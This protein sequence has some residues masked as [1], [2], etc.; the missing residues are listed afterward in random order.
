M[1]H[2]G[3]GDLSVLLDDVHV[4][5]GGSS[6]GYF[7]VALEFAQAA[8]LVHTHAAARMPVV[9][10]ANAGHST[11]LVLRAILLSKMRPIEAKKAGNATS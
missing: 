2:D 6:A 4:E 8:E 5:H 1:N 9:I 11:E 3:A 10:G 7:R